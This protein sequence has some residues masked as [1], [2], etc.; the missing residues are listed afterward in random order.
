MSPKLPWS[1]SSSSWSQ[2]GK[3]SIKTL[4]Y[5]L[6]SSFSLDKHTYPSKS[7]S[8]FQWSRLSQTNFNFGN[9]STPISQSSLGTN[10]HSYVHVGGMYIITAVSGNDLITGKSNNDLVLELPH[11]Q[12]FFFLVCCMNVNVT[13]CV[14]GSWYR[15]PCMNPW[16][17]GSGACVQTVQYHP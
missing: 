14:P 17:S 6:S 15:Q 11:T 8:W 13:H 1:L 10:K 4:V 16:P 12:S 5:H 9:V 2:G 3:T 7:S